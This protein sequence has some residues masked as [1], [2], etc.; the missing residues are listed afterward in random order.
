MRKMDFQQRFLDMPDFEAVMALRDVV[1]SGLENPDYYRRESDEGEFVRRHLDHR[2]CTIGL[3]DRDE[4]VAIGCMSL[5]EYSNTELLRYATDLPPSKAVWL[6][7]T[8]VH[9]R[10]RGK[11]LQNQLIR[12]RISEALRRGREGLTAT[13]SP[14]NHYSWSNLLRH[15]LR[16]RAVMKAYGTHDR[17]VMFGMTTEPE[18][19]ARSSVF[20]D[21]RNIEAQQLLLQFGYLGAESLQRPDGSVAIAYARPLG[22][23]SSG[24]NGCSSDA[25]RPLH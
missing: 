16:V 4:L 8:F 18:F 10:H 11:D 12:L 7:A 13:V 6:S 2:G 17:F 1:L 19:D 5:A 20:L 25:D 14:D 22:H 23:R 24:D 9:P 21:P 15:G 3:F